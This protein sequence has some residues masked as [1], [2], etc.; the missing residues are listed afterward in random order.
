MKSLC[1]RM[2]QLIIEYTL[3]ELDES[4]KHTVEEHIRVCSD[5][6]RTLEETR[7]VISGLSQYEMQE[8]SLA[9]CE[10]VRTRVREQFHRRPTVFSVIADTVSSLTRRPVFAGATVVAA[11]AAMF[12]VLVF[13]GLRDSGDI[14]D[15]NVGVGR[16]GEILQPLGEYFTECDRVLD[17]VFGPGAAETLAIQGREQWVHLKGQAMYLR[18]QT[19]FRRYGAL[20]TDL[21][22]LFGILEARRGRFTP[23]DLEEIRTLIS[24][25]RLAQRLN[26][27]LETLK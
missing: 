27:V 22:G 14:G 17:R 3:D 9:L 19:G 20:L 8:P 2:E 18:E 6:S 7:S 13:P 21:E 16:G 25:K 15:P 24:Q 4:E 1:D 26:R 10:S 12:F 11:L 23:Q 5:C